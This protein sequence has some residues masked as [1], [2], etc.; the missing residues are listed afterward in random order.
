M[1]VAS[2]F[3]RPTGVSLAFERGILQVILHSL[4][5]TF[6][7]WWDFFTRVYE[8]M[9][10]KVDQLGYKSHLKIGFRGIEV[11]M[12]CLCSLHGFAV[13]KLIPTIIINNGGVLLTFCWIVYGIIT[14]FTA[15]CL[16]ELTA[17]APCTGSTYHYSYLTISE[18]V[19]FLVGWNKILAYAAVILSYC[20]FM[21]S[22]I[23][24]IFFG[25][26]LTAEIHLGE[27]QCFSLFCSKGYVDLIVP[28]IILSLA[29]LES[30]SIRTAKVFIMVV[31]SISMIIIFTIIFGL[32]L[33]ID[34][35]PTRSGYKSQTIFQ[36]IG[37]TVFFGLMSFDSIAVLGDEVKKPWKTIPKSII[38]ATILVVVIYVVLTLLLISIMSENTVLKD[39]TYLC[40]LSNIL[41]SH[42]YLVLSWFSNLGTILSLWGGA[43][44]MIFN[45]SRI[46]YSMSRDGLLFPFLSRVSWIS[47]TP[48]VNTMFCGATLSILGTFVIINYNAAAFSLLLE[49]I[50]IPVCL[51][52]TRYRCEQK[53]EEN[54]ETCNNWLLFN[55]PNSRT[56]PTIVT[57]RISRLLIY[58]IGFSR[59]IDTCTFINI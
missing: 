10:T 20:T 52:V 29:Y 19:A 22:S 42:G 46:L 21:S 43:F 15:F 1:L 49:K 33:F 53:E 54:K 58:L 32:Y 39:D 2:S 47:H 59:P 31:T 8:R 44:A 55:Y 30:W 3:L 6:I 56:R 38:N 48:V 24:E 17:L 45:L 28:I 25:G 36:D 12:L 35:R 27:P 18:F 34:I 11:M 4:R 23:D 57:E 50:I 40:P 16:A 7:S 9:T 13:Y 5:W 37:E 26:W 14:M 51:L 41:E